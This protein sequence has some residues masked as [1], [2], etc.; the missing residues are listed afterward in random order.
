M[1]QKKE[2]KQCPKL[3]HKEKQ[4]VYHFIILTKPVCKFIHTDWHKIKVITDVK[5][6]FFYVLQKLVEGSIPSIL[7]FV[8]NTV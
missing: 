2:K 6:S 7:T 3:N 8:K 5:V 1:Y 4:N